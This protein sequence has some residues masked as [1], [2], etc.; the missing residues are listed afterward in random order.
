MDLNIENNIENFLKSKTKR[1]LANSLN[2]KYSTF[3]YNVH[4]I[5]EE[6][7]YKEFEIKK[8]NGGL[9]HIAAPISG[10]KSI[11]KKIAYML[12]NMYP[13][14]NSVHGYSKDK[15]IITNASSHLKKKF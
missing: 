10:I 15:G 7:K 9:R 12:L 8:K 4:K 14:K 2:I 13:P 6:K 11:Q 3:M 5:S 1:E